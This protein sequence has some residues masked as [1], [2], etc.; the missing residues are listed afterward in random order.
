MHAEGRGAMGG[1]KGVSAKEKAS[2]KAKEQASA[3]AKAREDADWEAA[4]A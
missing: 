3:A 4:G 2:E 1:K